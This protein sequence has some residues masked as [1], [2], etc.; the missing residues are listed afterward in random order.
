[1]GG[2]GGGGAAGRELPGGFAT[3]PDA[4]AARSTQGP[5]GAAKITTS[6]R[7]R[8][9]RPWAPRGRAWRNTPAHPINTYCVGPASG[10]TRDAPCT[11]SHASSHA[12]IDTHVREH[13]PGDV[14]DAPSTLTQPA[15]LPMPLAVLSIGAWPPV[16]SVS[17]AVPVQ[18]TITAC[19]VIHVVWA[20]TRPPHLSASPMSTRYDH[21]SHR[22]RGT[23]TPSKRVSIHHAMV[24]CPLIVTSPYTAAIITARNDAV[25]QAT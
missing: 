24:I 14:R 19:H 3:Y 22:A 18:H 9:R 5:R 11:Y 23:P 21:P 17:P 1:M 8:A 4:A 12:H 13:A 16:T 20:Y 15:C 7:D 2:E 25:L 10:P 6:F